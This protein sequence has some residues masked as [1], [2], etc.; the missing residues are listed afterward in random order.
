MDIPAFEAWAKATGEKAA[1]A[2]AEAAKASVL[3]DIQAGIPGASAEV[4]ALVAAVQTAI[5]DA[6][7]GKLS[8][9]DEI[10][11]VVAVGRLAYDLEMKGATA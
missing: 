6:R 2:A 4:Q 3:A 1:L 5:A 8:T 10:A 9:S 7:A 11:V